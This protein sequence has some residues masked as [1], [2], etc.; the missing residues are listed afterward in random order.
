MT[1]KSKLQAKQNFIRC[2]RQFFE[3][4]SVIEV[5]THH[6]SNYAGT[7]VH[8]NPL[9]LS[10]NNIQRFL[11]TSPE[12]AMKKLL[13]KNSGDIFQI[14]RVYRDDIITPWHQ[15]E[16]D[17]LE[18]YR[19]NLSFGAMIDEVLLLLDHIGFNRGH[20]L[21]K[22]KELC[23]SLVQWDP[24]M[25]NAA[26]E[27]KK[28]WP[29]GPGAD[30]I[31]TWFDYVLVEYV[32]PYLSQYPTSVLID[33]PITHAALAQIIGDVA[34]RFEVYINGVEVA[35]GFLELT[36]AAEQEKRF[37]DDL[38]QR[39]QLGLDKPPIDYEF[40]QA[41]AALPKCSGVAMGLDRVWALLNDQDGI[42]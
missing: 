14:C 24:W 17:M 6:L 12:F 30:C 41:L 36:D 35:N 13:A 29:L 23:Q 20:K 27:A 19:V 31:A 18:W 42:C 2:I 10:Y 33:Y 8:I 16:F 28:K 7:D 3:Q 26:A 22:I 40:L 4:R 34:K 25:L 37:L 15:P 9:N 1:L 32:E 5:F 11:H 39:E 38:R 21:F